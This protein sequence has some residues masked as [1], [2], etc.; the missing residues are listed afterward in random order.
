MAKYFR[1]RTIDVTGFYLNN[2]SDNTKAEF[3]VYNN[4][5]NFI[6]D[7]EIIFITVTDRAISQIWNRLE[8]CNISNKIIC[9][10]SG[11]LSSDIFINADKHN[12]YTC[13]VHPLLPFETDSTSVES[14]SKAY[15]SIEGSSYALETITKLIKVCGNPYC[16]INSEN[17]AKYHSAACFAS[18]FV[19]ALCHKGAELL[20]ECGF[21]Y[22]KAVEALSPLIISNVNNI[23]RKEPI[24]ALTGP[25]ERNDIDTVLKH[26]N[27]LSYGDAKLYKLLSLELTDIAKRKHRDR[28]YDNMEEV[29]K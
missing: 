9:H 12:A 27:T 24:N 8:N 5:Q 6:N 1:Y 19:V 20:T 10:C 3:K 14:I 25:I 22:S 17:K 15:F 2:H 23:C 29:L 26:L 11:S 28:N 13:S 21:E 18:N 4:L 16:I 7:S